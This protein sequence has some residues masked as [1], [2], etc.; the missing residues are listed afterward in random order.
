MLIA[1]FFLVAVAVCSLVV[2]VS[3]LLRRCNDAYRST[4]KDKEHVIQLTAKLCE[5]AQVDYVAQNLRTYGV[6]GYL[7]TANER[8][9]EDVSDIMRFLGL[10]KDEAIEYLKSGIRSGI[11]PRKPVSHRSSESDNAPDGR[12]GS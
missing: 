1:A 10:T 7:V 2:V 12:P 3:V 9:A 4:V 6:G 11:Q 8:I 5:L